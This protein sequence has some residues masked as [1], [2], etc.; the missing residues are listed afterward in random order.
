MANTEGIIFSDLF[1]TNKDMFVDFFEQYYLE[2]QIQ[3]D[4]VINKLNQVLTEY[5][6]KQVTSAMASSFKEAWSD[7]QQYVLLNTQDLQLIV[8]YRGYQGKDAT[9]SQIVKQSDVEGVVNGTYGINTGNDL[10]KDSMESLRAQQVEK[11]LQLHLNGFLNQLEQKI[12]RDEGSILHKYHQSLLH[13]DFQKKGTHITGQPWRVPFYG[14]SGSH[15]FGGQGLGQAYDAFMNHLGNYNKQVYSY[16]L[17]NGLSQN[18]T[19]L[20]TT[21]KNSVFKEEGGASQFSH[22]PKLLNES[23][24]HVGWYTGG[25]IIIVNPKTMNIVYNIQLKTTTANK[26]SVFAEKVS[27]IRSFIQQFIKYTPRQKGEKLFDFLLTSVSNKND[28]NNAPQDTINDIIY[29]E[30]QKKLNKNIVLKI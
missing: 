11:F 25:D 26:Q 10:I 4:L 18:S 28:F 9:F 20:N 2:N 29:N 17:N 30:L 8:A 7:F 3:L 19:V 16:L 14:K 12:T 13:S 24:N 5:Q 15:F 21:E 27:A 6:T 22:F 1:I 23:K